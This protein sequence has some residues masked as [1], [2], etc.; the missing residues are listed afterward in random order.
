LWPAADGSFVLLPR[1][2]HAI[3]A[4]AKVPPIRLIDFNGELKSAAESANGVEFA[5]QSN[6]RAMVKFDH[7]PKS[8][9]GSSRR[10]RRYTPSI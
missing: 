1:G 3:E 8:W 10:P 7:A 4:S 2:M 5:Y 6:T 9:L